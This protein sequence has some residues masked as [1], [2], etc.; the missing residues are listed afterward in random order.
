MEKQKLLFADLYRLLINVKSNS[1]LMAKD[2]DELAFGY[3]DWN[4]AT[5]Q[6]NGMIETIAEGEDAKRED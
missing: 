6:V 4:T 1:K 5:E 2:I 3:L